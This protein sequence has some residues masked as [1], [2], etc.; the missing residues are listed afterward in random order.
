MLP[1]E[2][3][4]TRRQKSKEPC[5]DKEYQLDETTEESSPLSR[6]QRSENYKARHSSTELNDGVTKRN[7]RSSTSGSQKVKKDDFAVIS[8]DKAVKTAL[9][10]PQTFSSTPLIEFVEKMKLKMEAE[11]VQGEVNVVP[12]SSQVQKTTG[13]KKDVPGRAGP[14]TSGVDKIFVPTHFPQ[15]VYRTSALTESV[16][17]NSIP[18][19][20]TPLTDYM[21]PMHPMS[22]QR[23]IYDV[24]GVPP[25][26]DDNAHVVSKTPFLYSQVTQRLEDRKKLIMSKL[27]PKLT[28]GNIDKRLVQIQEKVPGS[29]TFLQPKRSASQLKRSLEDEKLIIR[30]MPTLTPAPGTQ[31]SQF[32]EAEITEQGTAGPVDTNN[33]EMP[34]PSIQKRRSSWKNSKHWEEDDIPTVIRLGNNKMLINDKLVEI[35]YNDFIS[36]ADIQCYTDSEEHDAKELPARIINNAAHGTASCEFDYCRLGCI[37]STLK[38]GPIVRD[39][40]GKPRCFFECHCNHMNFKGN[41]T[42]TDTGDI[43]SRLRP[44]VSLLNWRNTRL[45]E[46]NADPEE[47][48]YRV[49]LMFC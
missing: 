43:R 38:H 47:E 26:Q 28:A 45:G 17:P 34:A 11:K 36:D 46:Q 27:P 4:V 3:P 9:R 12:K 19:K 48:T 33:F 21:H 37:C 22:K 15:P 23:G 14:S 5:K 32:K 13:I 18:F 8:L 2:R 24:G 41:P 42:L 30:K 20:M 35:D 7:T 6:T 1:Y 25:K 31:I 40:C 44:R 29:L 10:I 39:H 49:I 16:R